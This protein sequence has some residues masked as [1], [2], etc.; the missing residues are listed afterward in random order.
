M[1][2]KVNEIYVVILG[3]H[4]ED[5]DE[6]KSVGSFFT[7][8]EAQKCFNE[9]TKWAKHQLRMEPTEVHTEKDYFNV[10][11]TE[12]RSSIEVYIMKSKI[13]EKFDETKHLP[14]EPFTDYEED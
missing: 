2:T 3:L 10:Y 14:K 9:N 7:K 6:T 1:K 11:S 8:S 4:S 12:T 5:E 13:D